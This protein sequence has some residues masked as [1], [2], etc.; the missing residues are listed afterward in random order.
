M[1][2]KDKNL[3]SLLVSIKEIEMAEDT[4]LSLN[5]N[6]KI[7]LP[8]NLCKLTGEVKGKISLTIQ[9]KFLL[10]DGSFYSPLLLTCDRCLE[11]Y[12]YN[13]DFE[14]DEALEITDTPCTIS[15]LELEYDKCFETISIT[16][17]VDVGDI[18][19]QYIIINLPLKKV[20][21]P[22]CQGIYSSEKEE[23]FI[24]PRWGSLIELKQQ[25]EKGDN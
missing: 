13:L 10:L 14:I 7:D 5:I 11:Q 22:G 2:L 16:E 23:E 15:D 9:N 20:C 18:I 17:D 4:T 8:E 6:H 21:D 25:L 3:K 24:D 19:R 12:P 1:P